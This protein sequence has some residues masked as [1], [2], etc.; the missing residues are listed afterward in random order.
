MEVVLK[1][2]PPFATIVAAVIAWWANIRVRRQADINEELNR[3]H[4]K[5][6]AELNH[7]FEVASMQAQERFSMRA[8]ALLEASRLA[9]ETCYYLERFL[10]PY[11][12]YEP[13]PREKLI[14]KA[15][16]CFESLLKFRW[17]NH[18]F[19]WDNDKAS[20]A[21]GKIMGAINSIKNKEPEDGSFSQDQARDF[22][23]VA[24][25][26]LKVIREEYQCELR[27]KFA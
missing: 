10:T 22:L 24:Q 9:G 12:T 2:L 21:L 13:M 26:A 18:L 5:K 7:V 25:P 8:K 11:T 4:G 3:E 6:I 16:E 19:L 15:E 1:V 14:G 17:E 27:G 23:E 20:V